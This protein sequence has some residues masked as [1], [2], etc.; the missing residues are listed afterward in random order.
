MARTTV[1]YSLCPLNIHV[2]HLLGREK[3]SLPF[4]TALSQDLGGISAVVMLSHCDVS[5]SKQLQADISRL[6]HQ[7]FG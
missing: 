2:G 6:S 1:V 3:K 5:P 4:P 7:K